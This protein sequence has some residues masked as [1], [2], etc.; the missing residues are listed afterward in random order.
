MFF[1]S[2]Q[3]KDSL[4]KTVLAEPNDIEVLFGEDGE[5]KGTSGFVPSPLHA[6]KEL[7]NN[8]ISFRFAAA[9]FSYRGLDARSFSARMNGI[10]MN[11]LYDQQIPWNHWGGLNESMS[12][13]IV[14][15][16]VGELDFGNIGM[17][18]YLQLEATSIRSQ[19]SITVANGNRAYG[20]RIAFTSASSFNKKGLALAMEFSGR[21]GGEQLLNGGFLNS[22]SYL[23][24]IQK[25]ISVGSINLLLIGASLERNTTPATTNEYRL[26]GG[27]RTNP[28]WG[29]QDGRKRNASFF[30]SHQPKVIL[31][32]TIS[33]NENT[34][35]NGA[36]MYSSGLQYTTGFD[37][38]NAPDPRA[39]YYR[40]L[41]S[42]Q[43]DSVLQLQVQQQLM[44]NPEML[45]INWQRLY[46]V[47]QNSLQ[48][49]NG[50]T[51]KRATYIVESRKRS[52]QQIVI[53]AHLQEQI[54]ASDSWKI[55][56]DFT[57][58][59]N[60]IYKTVN[61]LLGADYY[62]NW[63][64]FGSNNIP[65]STGIQND[66]NKPDEILYHGSA[67]G[68]NYALQLSELVGY[69]SWIAR[70]QK[71]DVDIGA[72]TSFTNYQRVGYMRN[73]LFP[74]NSL[75]E[76]KVVSF[77]TTGFKASITYK[78][79][80]MQYFF[81]RALA[82]NKPPLVQHVFVSARVNKLLHPHTEN[83]RLFQIET[84]WI[85]N[86]AKAK[87]RINAYWL[88]KR[89]GIDLL[90]FYHDEYRS[91]VSY[92]VSGINQ[93][94]LGIETSLSYMLTPSLSVETVI[95][96]GDYRYTKAQQFVTY[97]DNETTPGETGDVFVKNFKVPGTPQQ[98]YTMGISYKPGKWWANF[99][100]NF[101]RDYW[102]DFNPLRRTYSA[103]VFQSQATSNWFF[104]QEK[105]PDILYADAFIGTS[106]YMYKKPQRIPVLLFLSINNCFNNIFYSG[107]YEQ[108]RLGITATGG[109]RFPTKYFLSPGINYS[110]TTRFNF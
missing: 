72:S 15:V 13:Q 8:A 66:L 7:L 54:T 28:Y 94:H 64:Q 83:E 17:N 44:E 12:N 65:N 80:G 50:V 98:A 71:L 21:K 36:L 49:I 10:K 60:H 40:Y 90:S 6:A 108:L 69:I 61:D 73:G 75:G 78:Q 22:F 32:A 68:Y 16:G 47:N 101:L 1:V 5:P 4:L 34:I 51:G 43:Q 86:G 107:G 105:L 62:V 70:K 27:K 14:F 24:S 99:A 42:Y 81:V 48:T 18:H 20:N 76:S 85:Y 38:Y 87:Y 52:T 82:L 26:I 106:L 35:I 56:I 29:Y 46:A 19:R 92:A 97:I 67:F 103:G 55:G 77:S 57:A 96:I 102:L 89:N 110:L 100:I 59:H 45:Q 23:L 109:N 39:D 30:F 2:A 58:E 95:L 9:R 37:W 93:L 33:P 25:K 104:P 79:S 88:Q 84:G 11:R 63:N 74:G 91:L 53:A 31:S 41:P 3:K